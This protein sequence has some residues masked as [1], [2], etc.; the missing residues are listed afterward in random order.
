MGDE[1]YL[2][3]VVRWHESTYPWLAQQRR[4]WPD[5]RG[6]Y[7]GLCPFHNDHEPGSFSFSVRGFRCFAC[8]ARGGLRKLAE[9][10]R[11]GEPPVTR[12]HRKKPKP[13]PE[14]YWEPYWLKQPEIWRRF[15]D[16]PDFAR[17]YYH[18][19]GFT[20]ETIRRWRLGYGRLPA[21]RAKWPR[22]ILPIFENGR[23]VALKG[24]RI[25]E[26]DTE[27]KWLQSGGSK[28]VLFGA[29]ALGPGKTVIVAEAPY[30][31]ILAMQE[32]PAIAAVA[33]S[34]GASTWLQQW[35]EQIAA[36][37]PGW[38]LVWY[39]CDDAGRRNGVKV[40]N[41]LL[42]AGVRAR[43]YRWPAGTQAKAD[44]ADV[45]AGSGY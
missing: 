42:A 19:R 12:I 27:A 41:S 37:R 18:R 21:S 17:D 36:S 44:L 29:E 43:L 1:A 4:R 6:E 35:T 9:A 26:Q 45:I 2:E 14:S 24:R 28:S 31:A 25:H 13:K 34:G 15:V 3:A 39:D 10:I 22:L 11:A 38:V 30:S 23:L 16:L 20:D 5:R 7:W 8:D 33:S 40:A 32:A